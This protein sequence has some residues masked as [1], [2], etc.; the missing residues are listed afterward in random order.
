MCNRNVRALVIVL[1]I[2]V[3]ASAMAR[4]RLGRALQR[5]CRKAGLVL[6]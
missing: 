1:T 2:S 3:F 6:A 4:M 5:R